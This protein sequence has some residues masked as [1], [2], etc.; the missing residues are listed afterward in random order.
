MLIIGE[1]EVQDH[2]VS[3]R[4]YKTKEQYTL[5]TGEFVRKVVSEFKERSLT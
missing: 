5:P 3:V 4:V 2:S 1:K